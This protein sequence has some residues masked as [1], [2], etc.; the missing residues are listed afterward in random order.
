MAFEYIYFVSLCI[1]VPIAFAITD[2]VVL[3]AMKM[4][5]GVLKGELVFAGVY[6]AIIYVIA[7][8]FITCQWLAKMPIDFVL[9]PVVASVTSFGLFASIL[10]H[11]AV[12]RH[13]GYQA[14]KDRRRFYALYM[15]TC[16]S[17]GVIVM[18][19]L[20]HFPG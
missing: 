1:A 11:S 17:I 8:C 19:T 15:P 14:T 13:L 10:V 9:I 5:G 6:C 16:I 4:K 20:T 7:S 18:H 3:R 2:C 12:A